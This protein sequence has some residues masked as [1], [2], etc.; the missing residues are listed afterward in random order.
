MNFLSPTAAAI[1]AA[2]T[3]PPLVAL[4]FLKLKRTVRVVPSTLLWKRAVEDLQVNSPFQRL[5]SSLL[6][7]LQLLI[8]VAAA[9]ALGKPMFRTAKPV[10]DTLILLIDR[11]ASMNVVEKD[12]RSRLEQ[13]KQQA[14]RAVDNMADGGR[15][16]VIA[17]CDRATVISSFDSDKEALKKKIDT[18]ESTDSTTALG[19]ALRLAEANAEPVF[20]VTEDTNDAPP[21]LPPQPTTLFLFTDGQIEDVENVAVQR[22]NLENFR[23]TIIGKRSDNVGIV[24]MDARRNYERPEILSVTASVEN[25]GPEENTFD[26]VLYI[27]GQPLDVQPVKLAGQGIDSADTPANG[28]NPSTIQVVVFDD[29]EFEGSGMVHVR[30]QVDDALSADNQAWSI[31]PPPRQLRVL[32]V[33]AGNSSL[34]DVLAA[35]SFDVVIMTPSEYENVSDETLVEN[36]RSVFDVVMFDRHD[37]ARLARGSY[38]FWGSVPEIEGVESR[39]KIDDQIIFNWD[40]THPVLRHVGVETL[41]V[42][43]WLHLKLPPEAVSLIDGQTSPVLAYFARDASQFLICAFG[44]LIEDQEGEIW[45]N[46]LWPAT[47]DFVVFVQNAVH[48]LGSSLSAV[49]TDSIAPGEPGTLPYQGESASATLHRPDGREEKVHIANGQ[50]MHYGRTR[51]VGPYRLEPGVSGHDR[52][53]VNLKSRSE[54]AVAP[55]NTITL[56][57]AKLES[58]GAQIVVNE[59][60][61]PY[62]LLTI[63]AVLLLEWVV[64]TRRVL[65]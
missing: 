1:A 20:I 18:I 2:L 44:L 45:R 12:G 60:A 49:G 32:L 43:Q 40:E 61:W 48:F 41:H 34:E 3:I 17:F 15:A 4:Y 56:A 23:L 54:S 63:L 29:V 37:T 27:D 59:P 9:L 52:F 8:L 28:E 6:L 53:V 47:L 24:A 30:L 5:R 33:T 55:A 51:R 36:G 62:F 16:M 46:T 50:V 22:L 25:F 65:V 14:Q 13:A 31:I 35:Q 42:E 11:S 57:S 10:E 7:W 21:A 39:G 64:Y 38:F 58:A 26:A 19:D